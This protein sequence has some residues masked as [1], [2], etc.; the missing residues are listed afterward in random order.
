MLL[1]FRQNLTKLKQKVNSSEN[2]F[3]IFS[4]TMVTTRFTKNYYNQLF[5]YQAK[6][7]SFRLI[8]KI[9][10]MQFKGSHLWPRLNTQSFRVIL[11]IGKYP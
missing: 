10:A 1:L 8:P 3:S 5:P 11:N 2:K 4:K 9:V 6:E 7:L